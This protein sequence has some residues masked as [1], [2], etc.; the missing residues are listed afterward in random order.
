MKVKFEH[1][2]LCESKVR[3]PSYKSVYALMN[4]PWIVE[5]RSN[6][7][8]E[9]N[10]HA[11]LNELNGQRVVATS[12]DFIFWDNNENPTRRKLLAANIWVNNSTTKTS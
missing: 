7:Y 9:R 2:F 1:T 4:N 3:T 8:L 10:D 11:D 12:G 5:I 6:L